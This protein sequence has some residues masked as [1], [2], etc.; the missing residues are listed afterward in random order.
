M[1][2]VKGGRDRVLTASD[3]QDFLDGGYRVFLYAPHYNKDRTGDIIY[4]ARQDLMDFY[5]NYK[6]ILPTSIT[7]WEDLFAP[8]NS[9]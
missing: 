6:Q 1:V 4:I 3:Y 9:I 2:Q 8:E 5:Q 7:Q